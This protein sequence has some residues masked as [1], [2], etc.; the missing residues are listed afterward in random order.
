MIIPRMIIRSPSFLQALPNA[1]LKGR[2]YPNCPELLPR[3]VKQRKAQQV[4][5][6]GKPDSETACQL[7]VG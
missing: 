2:L 4:P 5:P 1:G 3:G 6:I 7:F